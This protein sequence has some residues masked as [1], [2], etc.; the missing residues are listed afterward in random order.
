MSNKMLNLSSIVSKL[1]DNYIATDFGEETMI[2]NM[3]SGDYINLNKMGT[4]IWKLL[5]NPSS[6]EN[7]CLELLKI[8][9][10]EFSTC[11]EHV[12]DFLEKLIDQDILET[13]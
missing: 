3:K 13:K 4:S 6:I 10:V 1:P 5:E 2:M 8:F 7:I 11:Q 9:D 12:I